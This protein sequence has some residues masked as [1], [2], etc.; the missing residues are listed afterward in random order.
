MMKKLLCM[1]VSM[2]LLCSLFAGCQKGPAAGR[3]D[4]YVINLSEEL[5]NNQ[6]ELNSMPW[7]STPE[8]VMEKFGLSLNEASMYRV[9]LPGDR[10]CTRMYLPVWLEDME[11][12]A[13]MELL[14]RWDYPVP[15]EEEPLRVAL[16]SVNFTTYFTDQLPGEEAYLEKLQAVLDTLAESQPEVYGPKLEAVPRMI[17][18]YRGK[19]AEDGN[20]PELSPMERCMNINQC[21]VRVNEKKAHGAYAGYSLIISVRQQNPDYNFELDEPSLKWL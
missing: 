8:E 6:L 16:T 20:E 14:F 9:T 11:L 1:A 19:M 15:W 5:D 12:P 21:G 18:Q 4:R 7:F 3:E 13:D 10:D 2:L 17:R